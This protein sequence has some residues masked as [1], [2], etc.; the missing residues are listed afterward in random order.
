[1]T[2]ASV[3]AHAVGSEFADQAKREWEVEGN[4]HDKW[5]PQLS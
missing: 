2:W 5:A 3:C 4:K 1:M